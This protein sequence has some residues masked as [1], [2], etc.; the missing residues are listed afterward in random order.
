MIYLELNKL[1][2]THRRK[3]KGTNM[4]KRLTLQPWGRQRY[5]RLR[6]TL[7]VKEKS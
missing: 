2:L 6:E 3:N 5:L 7:T 4:A 1:I